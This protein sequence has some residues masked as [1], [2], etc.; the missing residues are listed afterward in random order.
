MG[1]TGWLLEHDCFERVDCAATEDRCAQAVD[2][3]EFGDDGRELVGL[4]EF[5]EPGEVELVLGADI[6]GCDGF[7]DEIVDEFGGQLCHVTNVRVS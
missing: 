1:W 3:V 5:A 7:D 2:G 4:D 6:E